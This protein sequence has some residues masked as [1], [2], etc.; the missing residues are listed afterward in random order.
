[1]SN[2]YETFEQLA[3]LTKL[4]L[5]RSDVN[6]VEYHKMVQTG[7]LDFY[8]YGTG[9]LNVEIYSMQQIHSMQK[10]KWVVR[11]WIATID[12][13]D[14]GGWSAPMTKEDADALAHRVANEYLKGLVVF[15]KL[16]DVNLALRPFGLYI[17]ME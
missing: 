7:N 1:M 17:G 2:R 10:D 6:G 12:D 9:F 3:E 4:K 8:D 13:G 14:M 11:I 16:S 5:I 15:P